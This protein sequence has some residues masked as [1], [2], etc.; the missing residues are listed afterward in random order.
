MDSVSGDQRVD[1]SSTHPGWG[2]WGVDDEAGAANYVDAEAVRRGIASVRT[3]TTVSLAVPIRDGVGFGLVGRANPTHHMLRTGGDY[4]AGL[5]ER[6]GFGFADDIISL[7]THSMTHVDALSHVWRD[8]LMYNGFSSDHV[9]SRGA[10][11]LGIDKMPPFCFDETHQTSVVAFAGAP[12]SCDAMKS[13]SATLLERICA[14]AC[15]CTVWG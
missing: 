13:S 10:R 5:P 3:G 2:R 15:E 4:A 9:T 7:P 1:D 6:G 14:G 12:V 8:R 11:R